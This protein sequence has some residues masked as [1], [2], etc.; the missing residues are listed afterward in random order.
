MK[1]EQWAWQGLSQ[2]PV[3]SW[4]VRNENRIFMPARSLFAFTRPDLHHLVWLPHKLHLD[5]GGGWNT[6]CLTTWNTHSFKQLSSW[7]G[8]GLWTSGMKVIASSEICWH[9]FIQFHQILMENCFFKCRSFQTDSSP[10]TQWPGGTHLCELE[11]KFSFQQLHFVSPWS[12]RHFGATC[13]WRR[14]FCETEPR[15]FASSNR[16]CCSD[17][18]V[19]PHLTLNQGEGMSSCRLGWRTRME[20]P[21]SSCKSGLRGDLSESSCQ[22]MA[23]WDRKWCSFDFKIKECMLNWRTQPHTDES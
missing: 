16:S 17:V 1:I 21:I 23:V 8:L 9:T 22:E 5:A 3:S 4:N 10:V 19:G 14:P 11:G 12:F 15:G 6:A 18:S 20:T 13:P 7:A 2:R